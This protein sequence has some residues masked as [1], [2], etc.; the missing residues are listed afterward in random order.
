MNTSVST[1]SDSS[2]SLA[3]SVSKDTS[4]GE[5]TRSSTQVDRTQI[6]QDNVPC[7]LFTG[8]STNLPAQLSAGEAVWKTK[9]Q[10]MNIFVEFDA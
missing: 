8:R 1:V 3:G 10:L 2:K 9:P 5:C 6:F 7:W 4:S